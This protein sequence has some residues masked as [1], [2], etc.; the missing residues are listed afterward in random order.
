MKTLSNDRFL[1]R[2]RIMASY[3]MLDCR[4]NFKKGYGG[5]ECSVCKVVDDENHRINYCPKYQ[6][7]NLSMSAIKFEFASIYS[8]N[9][10]TVKRTLEVINHLW[11]LEN[12]GNIMR[13]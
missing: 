12:G 1:A 3:H 8:E 9:E 6:D 2:I 11:N 7:R 10:K 4:R 13:M 5:D